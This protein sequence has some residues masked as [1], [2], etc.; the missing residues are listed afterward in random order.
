MLEVPTIITAAVS[1]GSGV[2]VV[3][4]LALVWVFGNSPE[5]ESE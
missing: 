1:L 3:M 2:L 4:V 5:A